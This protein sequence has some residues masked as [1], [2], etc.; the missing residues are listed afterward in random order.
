MFPAVRLAKFLVRRPISFLA[1]CRTV[2]DELTCPALPQF[3]GLNTAVHAAAGLNRCHV[4]LPVQQLASYLVGQVN[5]AWRSADITP[6][7]TPLSVSQPP[8]G[9]RTGTWQVGTAD[10]VNGRNYAQ[11]KH[12]INDVSTGSET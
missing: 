10:Q 1:L 9:H 12:F 3:S 7:G 5:G 8:D 6:C 4:R 11:V 2:S